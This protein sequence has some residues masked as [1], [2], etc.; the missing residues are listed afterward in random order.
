MNYFKIRIN[1]SKV[2]VKSLTNRY[3]NITINIKSWND[4][5]N[6]TTPSFFIKDVEMWFA[7][8]M[9]I[10]DQE[11]ITVS[12]YNGDIL[13]Q[14]E[15]F[16]FKSIYQQ[17]IKPICVVVIEELGLGDFMW[18][19]PFIKKLSLLYQQKVTVFGYPQYYEFIK[20]NP[21]V[22]N[23]FIY[24]K[25]YPSND[26]PDRNKKI[27]ESDVENVK[28]LEKEYEV[29]KIFEYIQPPVYYNMD[30]RQYCASSAGLTLKE[31]ELD[32][33]YSPEEYQ[34]IENLPDEYVLL[35]PRK[36]NWINRFVDRETLQEL[37][38]LLNSINIS[39]VLI[40]KDDD[41]C[42][43]DLDVKLGLNL[44]GQD[45]QNSLSQT[46]HLINKSQVFITADSSM[47][48]LAGSTDTNIL[49][50]GWA[51]N[52]Y[53]HELFRNGVRNYKSYIVKGTCPVYCLND[54][55]ILS[56]GS[57]RG[58]F[59]S[60]NCILNTNFSCKPDAKSIFNEFLKINKLN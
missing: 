13:I 39:V 58:Q 7:P 50:T 16:R 33:I 54:Y 1:E 46:W 38:N 35:Y 20:N 30:H 6:Y 17:N 40:G 41:S 44:V 31:K 24:N 10:K 28:E 26:D 18:A 47:Y 32:I 27:Y 2:Y 57:I 11:G 12:L 19:T 22:D 45:C 8:L 23:F 3:D 25:N 51:L 9:N 37:I 56:N 14:S 43:Y 49:L 55:N 29:F 4:L 36:M 59:G 42:Y 34:K 53:N 21:Y 52:P 60:I 15:K 5:I 48:L